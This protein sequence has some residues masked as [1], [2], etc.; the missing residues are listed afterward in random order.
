MTG[1]EAVAPYLNEPLVLS[2]FALFLFFG[3]L[4]FMA[5]RFPT[6]SRNIAGIAVLRLVAFGFVLVDRF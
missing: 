6:I 1:F 4:R 2:G 3:A 5:K